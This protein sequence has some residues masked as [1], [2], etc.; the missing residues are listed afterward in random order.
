MAKND[1]YSGK[2][3][4]VSKRDRKTETEKEKNTKFWILVFF[5]CLCFIVFA[6]V[7]K[8]APD[9]IFVESPVAV[10]TSPSNR[11]SI[12]VSPS[13]VRI[14]TPQSEEQTIDSSSPGTA[15]SARTASEMQEMSVSITQNRD[16]NKPYTRIPY[17]FNHSRSEF[18]SEGEMILCEIVEEILEEPVEV[19]VRPNFLRNVT[20]HCLEYDI[21]SRKYKFAGEYSGNFH[22]EKNS[23]F[24]KNGSSDLQSVKTRDRKKKE[25]SMK[26]GIF[27]F[28]VPW[29]VD[30]GK[31]DKNGVWK[32]VKNSRQTRKELMK[33]YIEPILYDYLHSFIIEK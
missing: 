29:T 21:Y 11:S 5:V 27:L 30:S 7:V 31:K 22:Y 28:C 1:K 12:Y 24:H 26:N 10:R 6:L 16:N 3:R 2:E 9:V 18:R 20:G 8:F 4:K 19:N 14:L 13:N 15:R 17:K 32:Y 33:K 25:L 23:F